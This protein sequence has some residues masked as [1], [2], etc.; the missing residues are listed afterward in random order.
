[1]GERLFIRILVGVALAITVTA[2]A[3]EV[4]Q[5]ATGPEQ[6]EIKELHQVTKR[7]L[8]ELAVMKRDMKQLK[9]SSHSDNTKPTV[10]SKSD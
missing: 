10:R 7:L 5:P 9:N 2:F 4:D 6:A 1:M 3:V 8:D